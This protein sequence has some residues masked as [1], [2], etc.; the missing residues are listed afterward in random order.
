MKP[1]EQFLEQM[2]EAAHLAKA[3][4]P[5]AATAVI[6]E[7][8]KASGLIPTQAAD[9]GMAARPPMVDLNAVPDWAK[10]LRKTMPGR[11][12][13]I[14]A[15]DPHAPGQFLERTFSA[16]GDTRRYK[17]YVP[18]V[19][20]SGPRPLIVMLHGCTQN[21]DDFAAGTAMN[22]LAEQHGCL[23]LY[24]E[25]SATANASHCWN[26]FE[27][28]HQ[29]RDGGEPSLLAAMTREVVETWQA[30][31]KRVY[32]AGL[33]AGGAMAAILGQAYPELYAAVGVHSGLPVGSARDLITGLAA[34][35]KA[36]ARAGRP[37]RTPPQRVPV[38]VFHG[39]Q[40]ST[41]HPGNGDAVLRQFVHSAPG[42]SADVLHRH[43]E[44]TEQADG[45]GYTRTAMRDRSGRTVAEYWELHGAGHCWSGGSPAG[46]YTDPAGPNASAEM[47]RFFL[48]QA[49]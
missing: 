20:A 12:P 7:A 44:R 25:Q 4:D 27:A 36:P 35:K 2:K 26:W 40:D 9:N 48:A 42:S 32:V 23:V 17:L 8:L 34:M 21:A 41:V 46:T 29:E 11:R 37:A 19:P 16:A 38:I 15:P 45:R 30:D 28:S 33:S 47:L 1:F 18:S 43:E 49:D 22:A 31:P 14:A 6:Q 3:K 10:A 5:A 13:G 24:P 39:D